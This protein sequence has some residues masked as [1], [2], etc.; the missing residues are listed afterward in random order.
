MGDHQIGEPAVSKRHATDLQDVQ[1]V[2]L[3]MML[4]AVVGRQ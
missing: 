1:N 2:V 4:I 3:D